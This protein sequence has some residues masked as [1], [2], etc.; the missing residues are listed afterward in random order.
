M[1]NDLK[2]TIL[3][4]KNYAAHIVVNQGGTSSGKTYAILQVLFCL[5]FKNQKQVITVV[6]LQ[7]TVNYRGAT[8]YIFWN[9]ITNTNIKLLHKI[10]HLGFIDFH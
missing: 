9:G 10:K 3:F 6:R 7:Q 4:K 8:G 5:G 1:T 2:S